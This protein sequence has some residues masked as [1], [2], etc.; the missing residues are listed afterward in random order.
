MRK[1]RIIRMIA[2][3]AGLLLVFGMAPLW[4]EDSHV[5]NNSADTLQAQEV[6][7]REVPDPSV[8]VDL[9][10]ERAHHRLARRHRNTRLRAQVGLELLLRRGGRVFGESCQ[11]VFIASCSR[12]V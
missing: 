4:A 8:V 7:V 5:F 11:A 3:T 2:M 12:P 1:A 9:E 6:L 10:E